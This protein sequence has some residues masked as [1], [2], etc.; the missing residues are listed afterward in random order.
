MPMCGRKAKGQGQAE[1][2]ET[3]TVVWGERSSLVDQ[4]THDVVAQGRSGSNPLPWTNYLIVMCMATLIRGTVMGPH[5]WRTE[6][7]PCLQGPVGQLSQIHTSSLSKTMP[8]SQP[9]APRGA[10]VS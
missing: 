1:P 7:M 9:P 4:A 5:E 10:S 6:R 2:Q 3:Q 8:R